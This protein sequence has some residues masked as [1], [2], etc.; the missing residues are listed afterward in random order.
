MNIM[1]EISEVR[2]CIEFWRMVSKSTQF[3]IIMF[4]S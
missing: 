1:E 2:S 4:Y 3:I